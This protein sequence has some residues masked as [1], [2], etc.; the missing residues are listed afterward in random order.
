MKPGGGVLLVAALALAAVGLIAFGTRVAAI[1]HPTLTADDFTQDFVS[2]KAWRAG[3][4]PYGLQR[5]QG[6]RLIDS[7][8]DVTSLRPGHRNPHT[9]AEFVLVA[10]LTSLKY[11]VARTIWL[12]L[13]ASFAVGG[14]YLV[15]RTYGLP[16]KWAG[17]LAIGVLALPIVQ[18]DLLYGQSGG[19]LLI[20]FVIAWRSL[21]RGREVRA[22][23]TLGLAA[24]IK[25]FP[26][27]MVIP[28]IRRRS[29]RGVASMIGAAVVL[30]IASAAAVGRSATSF[31]FHVASPDNFRFW[32]GAP[33]NISLPGSAYRWLTAGPWRHGGLDLPHVATIVALVVMVLCAL[34]AARSSAGMT[35]DHFIASLPWM[36]LA[37]PLTGDLSLVI[38]IPFVVATIEGLS[39]MRPWQRAMIGAALAILVIGTP[40]G[41]PAPAPDLSVVAIIF[42]FGLPTLALLGAAG[43]DFPKGRRVDAVVAS[44]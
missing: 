17:V 40:P 37:G 24:A 30:S 22:G 6:P 8:I 41:T 25:L 28:L 27:F 2:A 38:A 44:S 39:R 13:S 42:G 10:P 23:I 7:P 34:A 29:G 36:L 4:D 14:L 35:G 5:V 16:A 43:L 32:R 9:P 33:V 26:A 3:Q 19:I 1:Q 12:V 11:R 21:R 15:V 31:W 18:D 20:L